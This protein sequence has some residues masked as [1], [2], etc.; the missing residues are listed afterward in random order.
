M[1]LS[2]CK[3]AKDTTGSEKRL[4]TKDQYKSYFHQAIQ[5]KMKGNYDLAASLFEK[6]L[7]VNA[8][9]DA[10]HFAL[11]DLYERLGN[12]DKALMHANSA[13]ELDKENRWYILKLA[14]MYFDVGNYHKSAEY[15]VQGI[16]DEQNLEVKFKY[17]EAL[18]YS[19]QY[20]KAID[21]LNEIEIET[22]KNPQLS[23]TKH[24]MYLEM[25]DKESAQKELDE[26]IADSPTNLE[27]RLVIADYFLRTNQ[28]GKAEQVAKEALNIAPKN[29]EIHLILADIRLRNE[30]L[31][32]CF[33]HLEI[34]FEQPE[35]TLGRKVALI[36]GLQRYAFEDNEEAKRIEEGVSE[37][38][39]IIYNEEAQNDTLHAQYGYFLQQQNQPMKAIDQ[40]QKVVEINPDSFDSWQRLLHLQYQV[41]DYK[42]MYENG[43]KALELFPAQPT[44][45][46]LAGI[47]AYET[48]H[49]EQAEEWLYY[50]KGLVIDDHELTGEF[51][52]QLGMMEWEQK[53]YKEAQKY[54]ELA[55]KTDVYNGNIY[56][57]QALCYIEEG[58]EEKAM[59]VANKAL[60]EAPTNAFF[61]DVKGLI[62]FELKRYEQ[63]KKYF[64]NALIYEPQ[65]AEIL[66]H[67]GDVLFLLG[68]EEEALENWKKARNFGAYTERLI[69]KITDK[70]YY[71]E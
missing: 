37:L 30:D 61:L 4:N 3:G 44:I 33:Y 46:L 25:D 24:D 36:S 59:E 10:A 64:E 49:F 41:D 34:G 50:G 70:K 56:R 5:E 32:Q 55:K 29:G 66:E 68:K 15:F 62:Y 6:C 9:S 31:D 38:Y 20:K 8:E 39:R 23:L 21:L 40:Y 17:A 67:L 58:N 7:S 19:Q 16:D 35:V 11:S 53:N 48:A 22:G 1:G 47:A 69:K 52:H 63:A 18:I 60:D 71:A 43:N 13:Y 28:L 42:K 57:S 27:N 12:Q 26:L 14:N 2:A 54:F 51:E 65:N 45:Y